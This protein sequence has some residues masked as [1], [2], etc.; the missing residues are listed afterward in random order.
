MQRRSFLQATLGVASLAV[1]LPRVVQ[2]GDFTGP[3]HWHGWDA[4]LKTA[5]AHKKTICLVIYA[6]WCPHCRELAP[7]WQDREVV[8][9]AKNM[10]MVHQNVDER[11]AW[12]ER[13]Y[14][15]L[16]RYVPRIFFLRPDGTVI[17]G[18]TSGNE[19]F[20]Y[21]YQPQHLPALRASMAKAQSAKS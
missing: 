1:A 14:G 17:D 16:G 6:D 4:A 2:A 8:K 9:L 13:Q 21:F 5:A 10:V 7:A 11:P 18:I 3:I 19:K 15:R 12:L 20:P